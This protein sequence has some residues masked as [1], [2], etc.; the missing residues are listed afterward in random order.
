MDGIHFTVSIGSNRPPSAGRCERDLSGWNAGLLRRGPIGRA[1]FGSTLKLPNIHVAMCKGATQHPKDLLI[2]AQLYHARSTCET[3]EYP[4]A[5]EQL[6]IPK[7]SWPRHNYIMLGVHVYVA[8]KIC[9]LQSGNDDLWPRFA[10][11]QCPSHFIFAGLGIAWFR[12]AAIDGPVIRRKIARCMLWLC[13][14]WTLAACLVGSDIA[15]T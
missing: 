8:M 5:K 12:P 10:V 13:Q 6:N 2:E 7:T 14:D 9:N 11:W 4:C 15:L 1:R 3:F